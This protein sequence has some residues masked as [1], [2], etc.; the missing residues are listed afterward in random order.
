VFQ[1][2]EETIRPGL[3][4]GAAAHQASARAIPA[5]GGQDIL[6]DGRVGETSRFLYIATFPDD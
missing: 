4:S 5:N 1:R 6:A 2:I 3:S